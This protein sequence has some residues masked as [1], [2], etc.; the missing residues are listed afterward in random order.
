MCTT[1]TALAD[2]L[3][4]DTETNGYGSFRPS[5]QRLVQLAWSMGDTHH[6]MLVNDVAAINPDVPHDHTTTRCAQQGVPFHE[7]LCAFMTDLRNASR[8]VA[9]NMDFDWST[10]Q[11][12]MRTRGTDP[13]VCDEFDEIMRRKAFCTMKC[14]TDIVKLPRR[15]GGGYKYPTLSE[16][17]QYLFQEPPTGKL[18][19][20][21]VDVDVLR[22]CSPNSTNGA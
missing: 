16:L 20:A 17:Y 3:F 5:T 10:M 7:M 9:H 2:V 4:F 13:A 6:D 15:Y 12:E 18:H 1:P 19:D 11:H 22:G 21:M 14:T 8:V